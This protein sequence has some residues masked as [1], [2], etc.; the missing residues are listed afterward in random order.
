MLSSA[1]V[2]TLQPADWVQIEEEILRD[3]PTLLM[4][5]D[6]EFENRKFEIQRCRDQ[7]HNS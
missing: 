7:V 4:D 6:K 2:Y 3:T 5:L 1:S